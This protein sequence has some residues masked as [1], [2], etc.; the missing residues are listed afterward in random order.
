MHR[1]QLQSALYNNSPH[2]AWYDKKT[3]I[4]EIGNFVC[5]IHPV[6]SSTKKLY[7]RTQEEALM[8]YTNNRATIKWWDPHTKK[9]KCCSSVMFDEH[10][11][12]FGKGWPPGSEPT[13]GKHKSTLQILKIDFS[14]HPIIK[15]DIFEVN[16]NL[17]PR[18]TIIGIVAQYC[19]HNNMSYIYQ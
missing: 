10:N 17:L 9:I 11:N 3:S 1:R 14:Y 15:D 6:S 16:V 4:Q 19:E 8:G 12:K 7:D 5:D 18:G 13:I 2:F